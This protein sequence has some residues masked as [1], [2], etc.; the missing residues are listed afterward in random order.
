MAHEHESLGLTPCAF[1]TFLAFPPDSYEYTL[2]LH[3]PRPRPLEVTLPQSVFYQS[4]L[5][6]LLLSSVPIYTRWPFHSIAPLDVSQYHPTSDECILE[7]GAD[8]V[9]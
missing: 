1:R 5:C 9:V 3:Y 2:P 6:C 8:D 4:F 7:F